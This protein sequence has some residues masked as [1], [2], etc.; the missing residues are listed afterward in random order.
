MK[1][2]CPALYIMIVGQILVFVQK[3]VSFIIQKDELDESLD[4]SVLRWVGNS[5]PIV[6][7][8]AKVGVYGESVF[9]FLLILMWN[10]YH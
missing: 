9:Q 6:W 5:L 3:Q 1:C 10:S 4:S 7:Q 2:E 8:C